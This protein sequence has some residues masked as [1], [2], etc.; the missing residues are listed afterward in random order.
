MFDRKAFGGELELTDLEQFFR[1]CDLYPSISEIEEALDV[2][3]HGKSGIYLYTIV[4]I[5]IISSLK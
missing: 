4:Y 2:V 5:E 1:E 3:L